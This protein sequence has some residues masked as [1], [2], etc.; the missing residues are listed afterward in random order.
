MSVLLF[1]HSKGGACAKNGAGWL[2]ISGFGGRICCRGDVE[3]NVVAAL[4][5]GVSKKHRYSLVESRIVN[6][7]NPCSSAVLEPPPINSSIIIELPS[8]ERM[9]SQEQ[10]DSSC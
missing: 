10:T 1:H 8:V 7:S 4:T 6:G 3:E 2:N 5:A 9:G